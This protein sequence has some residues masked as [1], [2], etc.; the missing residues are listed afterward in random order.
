MHIHYPM[1]RMYRLLYIPMR[2]YEPNCWQICLC[3]RTCTLIY[4]QYAL[5]PC[6]INSH[7]YLR[8][9]YT[10]Q[11]DLRPRHSQASS[12]GDGEAKWLWMENV[13]LGLALVGYGWQLEKWRKTTKYENLVLAGATRKILVVIKNLH[14][15]WL[16]APRV[17]WHNSWDML[18]RSFWHSIWHFFWHFTWHVFWH[19]IWQFIWHMSC[20]LYSF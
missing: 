14:F 1:C 6:D 10:P 15:S 17:M 19:F 9:M 18:L 11:K 13:W 2:S 7:M 5:H 8:G 3:A 4:V 20:G 12:T 16:P